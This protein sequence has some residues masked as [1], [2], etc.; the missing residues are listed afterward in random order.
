[1]NRY[2]EILL[3][4][5]KSLYLNLR[6]LPFKKAVK[7]PVL[8]RYNTLLLSCSGKI[9]INGDGGFGHV[10]YGFGQ[11]GCFDKKFERSIWQVSGNI[12]FGGRASFGHGSRI[13]VGD[14]GE[15]II[16]NKFVN[17]AKISILCFLR[18]KLGEDMLTSW[19]T[20]I[21]D[22]DFHEIRDLSNEKIGKREKEII[23]GNHVWIGCRVTIIKGTQIMDDSII[24]AGA[25]VN[26]K[27]DCSSV[28]LAGNPATVKKM[29]VSWGM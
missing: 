6:M 12:V 7:L 15:L 28:L 8:V 11:V 26:K 21:M 24:A 4:L 2:L 23:I 5:P 27:F 22:T 14:K 3:S 10:K 13:V 25:V 16:G 20:M 17:T 9:T 19:D 1:M 18:I 29:G